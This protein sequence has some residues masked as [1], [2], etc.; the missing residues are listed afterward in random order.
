VAGAARAAR[1][2]WLGFGE[3]A[4]APGGPSGPR[5]ASWAAGEARAGWARGKRARWAARTLAGLSGARPGKGG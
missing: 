2:R 3:V 4:P 1:A 5:A